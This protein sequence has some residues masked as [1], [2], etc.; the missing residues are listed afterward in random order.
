MIF[1]NDNTSLITSS[2]DN[3]TRIYDIRN[4]SK[5]VELKN[6]A[7][8][9][10]LSKVVK[11]KNRK[12]K[13][14]MVPKL[15]GRSIVLRAAGIFVEML[16]SKAENAGGKVEEVETRT[17]KLSQV[18]H[19]IE[20]KKKSLSQRWHKCKCGVECQI[21][22]YSAYLCIYVEK[23]KL[24]VDQAK[25]DWSGKDPVLYAAMSKLKQSIRGNKFLLP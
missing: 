14:Q 7:Y 19:S 3:T 17:T 24:I 13:L 20:E 25:A 23:E 15:Y 6:N 22:L 5:S 1:T 18:C 10:L 21:D 8:W 9:S 2:K 11:Y 16:R 4:L 12:D